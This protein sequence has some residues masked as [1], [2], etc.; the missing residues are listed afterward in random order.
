MSTVRDTAALLPD[1]SELRTHL[2]ALA[3]LETAIADDP[4]YCQYTFNG[5]WGPTEE[6]A[7]M[8][9][10]SGDDFSALFTPAGVLIRGFDHE[11]AMS[12]YGTDD[13]QVWPGVIDEVPAVLR[14][15]L[16]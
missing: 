14:P 10:G 1:P 4:Q 13:E 3:V 8:E 7:L 12:P 6:A 11:S 9:N 2:G 5:S 16:D 15:L